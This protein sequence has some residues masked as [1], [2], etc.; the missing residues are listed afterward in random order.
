MIRS[1]LASTAD[2]LIKQI[3]VMFSGREQMH[4]AVTIVCPLIGL[5]GNC[6]D[7]IPIRPATNQVLCPR[8]ACLFFPWMYIKV[9]LES[10]FKGALPLVGA[11]LLVLFSVHIFP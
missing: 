3:D 4:C 9:P 8:I 7:T 5:A 6:R 11:M 10:I 2:A 1:F